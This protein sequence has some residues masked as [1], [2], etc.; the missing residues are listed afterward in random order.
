MLRPYLLDNA[1]VGNDRIV[2]VMYGY[3]TWSGIPFIF[4][5]ESGIMSKTKK[6]ALS[7]IFI[8]LGVILSTFSIPVGASRCFPV[9]H[10]INVLSAVILGPY[11]GVAMA[12]ITSFIRVMMG[13]GTIL[14]FP[15]SM[16]GA[17]L[18]GVLFAKFKS[19]Y[20]A[21]AGEVFG[22]GILGAI[23]AYPM[24]TLIL[25]KNAAVFAFVIPFSIST[26]G[27]SVLALIFLLALEKTGI[28]S[29]YSLGK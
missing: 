17:L 29:E 13:T 7:G 15:G 12:F 16:C 4:I 2:T 9:Q 23:V 18:S 26:I 28:L 27:G 14:A 22:T 20:I 5:K 10:L 8:A 25:S 19:K 11:Y 6:L 3:A 24:A 1:I 21:F